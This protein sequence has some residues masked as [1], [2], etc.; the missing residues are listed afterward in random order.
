MA[1][2]RDG[3][4]AGSNGAFDVNEPLYVHLSTFLGVPR[5]ED[6]GA[7]DAD[8]IIQGVPFDLATSGRAGARHGPA[9]IRLASANLK[10]EQHRWPWEF[11][12]SD[13]LKVADIGDLVFRNGTPASMVELLEARTDAILA[14]GKGVV[15]LGGD[16]Y[17]ALPLLR[18]HHRHHGQLSLLHFD[19]H[20][21]TYEGADYHHGTMF[22]H[23]VQEGLIDPSRSVQ[24]GIRTFYGKQDHP[25]TVLDA[26]WANNNGPQ[27]VIE[28]IKEIVGDNPVYVS[29]DIDCLDPAYAPGTGTPVAGGLSTNFV[30]QV[31]RALG[32]VDIVGLDLMEVSP[33]YDS[34][35]I[36]SLAGATIVLELLHVLAARKRARQR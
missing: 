15:S 20:T 31:I 26:D 18:S 14:A 32:D 16:H 9:A 1:D 5:V 29:F 36:T 8:V 13:T 25:F 30:L 19:A 3:Q 35:E 28:K 7:S 4:S 10:W 24:V 22:H 34:A 12:L 23:A 2:Q 11:A 27:A 33:P 21:D 6:L 17:V